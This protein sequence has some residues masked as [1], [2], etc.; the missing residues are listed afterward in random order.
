MWGGLLAPRSMAGIVGAWSH[1][2]LI[3]SDLDLSFRDTHGVPMTSLIRSASLSQ[4]AEVARHCGLDPDR[5]LSQ[6]GLPPR[7]LADP[8]LMVPIDAV[9]RLLEASAERS[10]VES[11]G[12]LMAEARSLGNL[13]PF[14]LLIREQPTLRLALETFVREGRRLNDAL[15]LTMEESSDVVVLREELIVGG[16]GPIRQSTELAIGVAFRALCAFLGR[17]WKPRRVCFAHETPADRS[18]HER[19]FGRNVEFG[20]DFNGIVC[21]RRDLDVPNLNADAGIARLAQQML[22]QNLKRK[23]PDLAIQVRELVVALLGTGACTIDRVAQHLGVDRRTIHRRLAHKGLTFSTVV[24]GVRRE[25]AERYVAE[26]SRTLAEVSLMLGFSAPSGF[27][28]WYRRVFSV[29]PMQGRA[30]R[31]ERS[32]H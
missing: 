1:F 19:I 20:H 16:S 30:Q 28:R 22:E 6:F 13:G 23:D 7:S 32:K 18:V 15:F 14:G 24:D 5:M 25:L 29:T 17:D 11:F 27:S 26:G 3:R 12:L 31:G 8:E 10:G 2:E 9:R 21:A 4:Y